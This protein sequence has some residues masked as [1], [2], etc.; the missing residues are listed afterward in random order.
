M[1]N[2]RHAHKWVCQPY[3]AYEIRRE[4]RVRE[5]RHTCMVYDKKYLNIDTGKYSTDKMQTIYSQS[6]SEI[7]DSEFIDD[8]RYIRKYHNL[9]GEWVINLGDL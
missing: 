7:Y 6:L 2:I 9:R 5:S 1:W 4:L 3:T 8:S